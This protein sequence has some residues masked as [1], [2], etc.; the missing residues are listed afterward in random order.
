ME[1]GV[2]HSPS[3]WKKKS[4]TEEPT[5]RPIRQPRSGDLLRHLSRCANRIV[6]EREIFVGSLTGAN[7]ATRDV[8]RFPLQDHAASVIVF[9]NHPRGDPSP[10]AHDLAFTP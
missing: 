10:S 2:S 1:A 5:R 7:V 8:F 6:S 9:H 4:E 3:R